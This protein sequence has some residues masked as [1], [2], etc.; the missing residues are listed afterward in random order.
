MTRLNVSDEQVGGKVRIRSPKA[1]RRGT[2]RHRK[3]RND[4]F[5]EP[6]FTPN[7][8]DEDDWEALYKAERRTRRR[9][10]IENL[11]DDLTL[12]REGE[13]PWDRPGRLKQKRRFPTY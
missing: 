8:P 6:D 5:D 10:D 11:L 4:N 1:Q 13:L 9:R 12:E 2:R 7:Y 3:D